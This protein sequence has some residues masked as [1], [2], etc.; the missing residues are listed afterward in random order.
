MLAP[1]GRQDLQ[2]IAALPPCLPA[3]HH[4]TLLAP[5]DIC[6]SDNTQLGGN[7]HGSLGN[8]HDSIDSVWDA[9]INDDQR[10]NG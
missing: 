6:T 8:H 9:R 3:L 7:N 4:G 5:L 2:L 1:L 10:H